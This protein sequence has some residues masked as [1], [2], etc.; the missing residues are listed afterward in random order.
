MPLIIS[1]LDL[2]TQL[3]VEWIGY[4]VNPAQV[5][6]AKTGCTRIRQFRDLNFPVRNFRLITIYQ[7]I[8][9]TKG[10]FF[11]NNPAPKH[12]NNAA[13]ASMMNF[14]TGYTSQSLSNELNVTIKNG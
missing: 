7:M 5:C 13:G 4:L 12:R 2:Q 14:K 11:N 6:N 10:I 8:R 3:V 9:L 1:L